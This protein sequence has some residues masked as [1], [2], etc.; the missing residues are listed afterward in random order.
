MSSAT[1]ALGQLHQLNNAAARAGLVVRVCAA[2]GYLLAGPGWLA[3]SDDPAELLDAMQRFSKTEQ[4]PIQDRRNFINIF[5]KD[6]S[7]Y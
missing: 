7:C 1:A 5:L 4:R 2:G 3:H 6:T